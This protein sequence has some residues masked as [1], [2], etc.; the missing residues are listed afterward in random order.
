LSKGITS[1]LMKWIKEHRQHPYPTS[2]EKSK[3]CKETGLSIKQVI[4]PFNN[5]K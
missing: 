1:Y 5:R 2:Q 4:Y 3:L